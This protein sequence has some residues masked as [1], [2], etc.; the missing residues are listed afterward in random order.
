MSGPRICHFLAAFFG[1]NRRVP[2][3]GAKMIQLNQSDDFD[4]FDDFDD[5]EIAENSA[6]DDADTFFVEESS[7]GYT[8]H[9][10]LQSAPRLAA[11]QFLSWVLGICSAVIAIGILALPIVTAF[12]MP[13]IFHAGPAV[14]LASV[15]V[16]MFWYSSRGTQPAFQID[17]AK[18]EIREVVVNRMGRPSKKA[19]FPFA[20][21]EDVF[22]VTDQ[23]DRTAQL[24]LWF[25]KS[26]EALAI[27]E[28]TPGQLVRL[29][30]RIAKDLR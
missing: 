19:A 2:Q 6:G 29:R 26:D 5:L 18:R 14:L 4:D 10:A 23:D 9:S 13:D 1:E 21:I 27:A 28:A 20:M 15:A 11:A 3:A 17:L 8:I 16:Y 30:D 22:A 25:R 24:V 12:T 7:W